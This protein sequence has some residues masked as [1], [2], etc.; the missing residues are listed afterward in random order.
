MYHQYH[1][2]NLKTIK[3]NPILNLESMAKQK[4]NHLKQK[5]IRGQDQV[6]IIDPIN[7]RQI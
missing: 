5:P 3:G 1:L 2:T 7:Q 6:K 4:H